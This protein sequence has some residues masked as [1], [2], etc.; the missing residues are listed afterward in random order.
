MP[1]GLTCSIGYAEVRSG[2]TVS[3]ALSRADA[4]L[5]RAKR[6]GRNRLEESVDELADDI[7]VDG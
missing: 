4:A 1:C 3:E 7:A 5:Y 6:N 2:E